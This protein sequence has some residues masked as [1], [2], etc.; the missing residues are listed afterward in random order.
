MAALG[1]IG[2]VVA[3]FL[4]AVAR[5][6]VVPLVASLIAGASWIIM[7]TTL[8]VSAQVALPEWV[9]GRGLAIFLT[10]FFGAMTFGSAVWGESRAAKDCPSPLPRRGLNVHRDAS[11]LAMEAANRCRAEF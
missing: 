9:R 10:V 5:E 7:L 4:F 2:T 6:P 1:T 8:F 11:H 3:L